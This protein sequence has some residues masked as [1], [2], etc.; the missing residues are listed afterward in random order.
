MLKYLL[1]HYGSTLEQ[2]DWHSFW[3]TLEHLSIY[4]DVTFLIKRKSSLCIPNWW[5]YCQHFSSNVM[6]LVWHIPYFTSKKNMVCQQIHQKTTLESACS[7]ICDHRPS[8]SHEA[9]LHATLWLLPWLGLSK[10]CLLLEQKPENNKWT[11]SIFRKAPHHKWESMVCHELGLAQG[12]KVLKFFD[13]I[14]KHIITQAAPDS[15][16]I[17]YQDTACPAQV[18]CWSPFQEHQICLNGTQ[19][20]PYSYLAS[21]KSVCNI[22]YA[23]LLW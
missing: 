19:D 1:Q 12:Y 20:T 18:T 22:R 4:S 7:W 23:F 17:K 10:H 21:T 16:L 14:N 11:V 6:D 3:K 8:T 15:H 9:Q 13:T 5:G 2:Q